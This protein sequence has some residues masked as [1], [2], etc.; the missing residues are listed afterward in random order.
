[1]VGHATVLIQLS[2]CNLLVDPVWSERAS[3]LRWAGPKRANAPGVAFA[4]LP[5]IDAVLITHN[6]YDHLD[7]A[8]LRLIWSTHRPRFIADEL[9][10]ELPVIR[11]H[12]VLPDGAVICMGPLP[13]DLMPALYRAA[14]Q[15]DAHHQGDRC[16]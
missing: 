7:L 2:G 5:P 1:M 8:T 12:S 13:Q 6:H 3:P 9:G 16:G 4:D 10:D 11:L 15:W 14:R